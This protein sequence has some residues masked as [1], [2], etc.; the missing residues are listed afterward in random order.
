MVIDEIMTDDETKIKLTGSCEGEA[1]SEEIAS[2]VLTDRQ[3]MIL[4]TRLCVR[5]Q[6]MNKQRSS[7]GAKIKV[8]AKELR[9]QI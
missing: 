9:R 3:K 7:L 5:C 2:N 1:S 8:L 4:I 6:E